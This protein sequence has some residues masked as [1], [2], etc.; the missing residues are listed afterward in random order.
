MDRGISRAGLKG[1]TDNFPTIVDITGRH[2]LPECPWTFRTWRVKFVRSVKAARQIV[3]LW[4]YL[5]ESFVETGVSFDSV[6][7]FG[8]RRVVPTGWCQKITHISTNVL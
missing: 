8:S 5:D 1:L 3:H 6:S 7:V 4:R 2:V